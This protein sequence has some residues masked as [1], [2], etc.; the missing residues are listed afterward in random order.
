MLSRVTFRASEDR[1]RRL[2]DFARVRG[3]RDRSAAV[4]VAV[5][6]AVMS[7]AARRT[8]PDREELLRIRLPRRAFLRRRVS[9]NQHPVE[10]RTGPGASARWPVRV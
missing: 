8:V 6:E 7:P 10:V 3:L 1:L 2:D 9:G 5:R 4:R